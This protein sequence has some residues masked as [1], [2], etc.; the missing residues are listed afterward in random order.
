MTRRVFSPPYEKEK[1]AVKTNTP[2][3]ETVPDPVPVAP[4][5]QSQAE[6]S[7]APHKPQAEAP[8]QVTPET[9]KQVVQKE[10]EVD[11]PE[12]EMQSPGDTLE[13]MFRIYQANKEKKTEDEE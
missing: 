4:P 11:K 10:K 13:K 9:P 5:K 2:V 6:P 12:V 3:Q 8:A 1:P 7:E